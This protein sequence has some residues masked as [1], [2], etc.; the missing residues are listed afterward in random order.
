MSTFLQ[1]TVT[2]PGM[3]DECA[4]RINVRSLRYGMTAQIVE[5]GAPTGFT[6]VYETGD[7]RLC[8]GSTTQFP[9]DIPEGR[10]L[11]FR[12]SLPGGPER[13]IAVN[14]DEVRDW[15]E[16]GAMDSAGQRDCELVW[17]DGASLQFHGAYVGV[18]PIAP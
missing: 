11:V 18:S 17:R 5:G 14:P 12:G 8:N 15:I 16:M 1:L 9:L 7:E 4:L 10:Q 6:L 13:F 3:Q 2:L